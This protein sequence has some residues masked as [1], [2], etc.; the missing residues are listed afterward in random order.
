MHLPLLLLIASV[1]SVLASGTASFSD[2]YA[3]Q[4]ITTRDEEGFVYYETYPTGSFSFR[5]RIPLTA[6]LP[7]TLNPE[8]A[9]SLSLG[10]WSLEGT[11][12]QS[13][14]KSGKRAASFKDADTGAVIKIAWTAKALTWSVTGRTGMKKNDDSLEE[15]PAAAGYTDL[16]S[17][18]ISSETQDPVSCELSFGELVYSGALPWKG[19]V[20][21]RTKSY[22]R[23]D[24]ANELNFSTISMKGTGAIQPGPLPDEGNPPD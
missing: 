19:S 12:A 2:S 23:G 24:D 5:G 8:T 4:L 18:K 17:G 3:D 14:Y 13:N 10:A 11:V 6:P 22:G 1:T 16:D 15:S 20:K 21:Q 7:A 9:V